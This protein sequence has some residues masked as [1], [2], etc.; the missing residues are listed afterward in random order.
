MSEPCPSGI[1]LEVIAYCLSPG[2]RGHGE[3]H[4]HR[5]AGFLHLL[6]LGAQPEAHKIAGRKGASIVQGDRD[7]RI[8]RQQRHRGNGVVE[9]GDVLAFRVGKRHLR[10]NRPRALGVIGQ[11][12]GHRLR[13]IIVLLGGHGRFPVAHR[14]G[15]ARH[16]VSRHRRAG[17]YRHRHRIAGKVAILIQCQRR[18][19]GAGLNS[20]G[21][22][23]CGCMDI[24]SFFGPFHQ[25][26]DQTVCTHAGG[27]KGH[28]VAVVGHD[29]GL[30]RRFPYGDQALQRLDLFALIGN[31]KC[32]LVTILADLFTFIKIKGD[33]DDL[34]PH[35]H[36]GGR[37]RIIVCGNVRALRVLHRIRNG[38][39]PD[40][41]CDGRKLGAEPILRI[42]LQRD[43]MLCPVV[44]VGADRLHLFDGVPRLQR[45]RRQRGDRKRLEYLA[46]VR[47]DRQ[48]QRRRGFFDVLQRVRV[49]A[50]QL[51]TALI[52]QAQRV[53]AGL[54]GIMRDC[55]IEPGSGVACSL[56]LVGVFNVAGQQIIAAVYAID[57][58]DDDFCLVRQNADGNHRDV[59]RDLDDPPNAELTGCN[60]IRIAR[61]RTA[62]G[63]HN[64][65]GSVDLAPLFFRNV[66]GDNKRYGIALLRILKNLFFR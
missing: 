39:I 61:H 21:H 7:E 17:R 27:G 53:G 10:R 54:G 49:I 24:S 40:S 30:A 65:R 28:L 4:A 25:F 2:R 13:Y 66:L 56:P 5:A 14:Q 50:H 38:N 46:L 51:V 18:L 47:A 52:L 35:R 55:L 22:C 11:R 6:V 60:L 20:Q 8:A 57:L 9:A 15:K 58:I 62:V 63:V 37:G 59:H 29:A 1:N 48:A 34:R 32:F 41:V 23:L 19:R 36:A 64:L 3:I 16:L 31:K 43:R 26:A 42:A 12:Q 33:V 44:S 45:I